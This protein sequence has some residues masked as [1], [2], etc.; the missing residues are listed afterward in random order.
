MN[1]LKIKETC[2]Y[3]RDLD[4][5][6]EFYHHILGLELISYIKGKHIFFRAGGSVLLCF[7]PEDSR[8]KKSPPAHYADGKQHFAFEVRNE[9]YISVKEE[10]RSKGIAIID[11]IVWES[12]KESFYFTDPEENILEVLPETGIW[13]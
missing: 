3:L 7:N 1:P 4:K 6:K 13:D 5:A 2:L 11:E 12:G 8:T 10:I 9:E